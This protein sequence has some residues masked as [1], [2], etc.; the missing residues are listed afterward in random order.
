MGQCGNRMGKKVCLLADFSSITLKNIESFLAR[1][2]S[3]SNARP[4]ARVGEVS[5]EGSEAHAV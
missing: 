3:K 2:S 1:G 5:S 4:K